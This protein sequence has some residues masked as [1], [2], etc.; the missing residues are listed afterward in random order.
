MNELNYET[1][2]PYSDLLEVKND[3]YPRWHSVAHVIEC[4]LLLALLAWVLWIGP[5]NATEASESRQ[6]SGTESPPLGTVPDVPAAAEALPA[7]VLS[8]PE[9]LAQGAAPN[10]AETAC[11]VRTEFD[12]ARLE[13]Y[14]AKVNKR[15]DS[16]AVA[17]ALIAAGEAHSVDPWLLAAIARY[18]SSMRMDARG[19]A[20]ERGLVQVHPIHRKRMARLGLDFGSERDRLDFA[21]RLYLERGLKPWSVRRKALKEYKRI[22]GGAE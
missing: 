16:A 9:Y 12:R 11:K 13:Q 19:A 2:Y 17:A 22:K 15:V 20:G 14:I 8:S 7:S 1:E 4:A 18:E 5:A 10:I 21:C 3:Y 6:G